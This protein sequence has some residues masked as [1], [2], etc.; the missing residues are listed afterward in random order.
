MQIVIAGGSG[1]VGQ[2]LV[3][4]LRAGGHKVKLLVRRPARA[5]DEIEWDP[6]NEEIPLDA[7]EGID[8]LINL[9]GTNVACRWTKRNKQAIMESRVQ[10]TRFLAKTLNRLQAPPAVWINASGAGYYGTRGG[11]MHEGSPS[12][13]GFLA[14]V[15]REWEGATLSALALPTRIVFLRMGV[16][17]SSKGGALGK[18]LPPFRLGL[19]GVL[20]SGKQMMSWIA[21]DDLVRI[22]LYCLTNS[23]L[24][25]PVNATSPYPVTNREWTKTL[26]KVL[27]RPTI[28]PLPAWV[29]RLA[30]GEMADEM[31]LEGAA[32]MPQKLQQAGYTFEYPDVESALK[33][34]LV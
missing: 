19:G 8:A 26:G 34:L 28:F 11:K 24:Q 10:T 21:I 31:L 30:F 27:H 22:F 17:L 32:V 23:S 29:A 18:M 1:L 9:A 2:S 6:K 7:L 5:L 33:H 14:S 4:F 20:G 12:G 15:C 16:V 25:G 3:Q 13:K